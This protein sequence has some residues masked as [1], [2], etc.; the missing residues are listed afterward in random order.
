MSLTEKGEIKKKHEESQGGGRREVRKGKRY[1]EWAVEGKGET[2]RDL[3]E[4]KAK[5]EAEE[6]E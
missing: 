3:I 4:G 6:E 5:M 2:G 1:E